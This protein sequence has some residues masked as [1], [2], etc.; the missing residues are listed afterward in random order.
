MLTVAGVAATHAPAALLACGRTSTGQWA[1]AIAFLYHRWSRRAL[2]TVWVPAATVQ[3][4]PGLDYHQVPRVQLVG[5]ADDWPRLPPRY[6]QAGPERTATHI[7][8][9]RPSPSG[10]Y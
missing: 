3:P 8:I 5:T 1:A 6:P 2:V 10:S 7:H 9:L 4:H